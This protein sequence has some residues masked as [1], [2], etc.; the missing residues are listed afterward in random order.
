MKLV[1]APDIERCRVSGPGNSGCYGPFRLVAEP[2]G[3]RLTVIVSDGRDWVEEGLPLPAW[4]HVSVSSPFG[5]PTWAEMAWIKDQFWEPTECVVEFHVPKADHIN[6]HATC[7]H[8][9]RLVGP[10]FPMPPS[11]CV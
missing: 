11:E 1:L 5:C 10:G 3:R 2:T 7:L 4:E 9:W 6:Q 8:L